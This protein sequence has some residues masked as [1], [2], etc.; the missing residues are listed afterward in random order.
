MNIVPMYCCISRIGVEIYPMMCVTLRVA[1][2]NR[3]IFLFSIGPE[4][5]FFL[6][7]RRGPPDLSFLLGRGVLIRGSAW[8][9]R[10]DPRRDQ[11]CSLIRFDHICWRPCHSFWLK[12]LTTIS[13]SPHERRPKGE[14][15]LN[16][17]EDRR[18]AGPCSTAATMPPDLLFTRGGASPVLRP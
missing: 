4:K 18:A 15:L 3:Q 9:R 10:I 14:Y 11:G 12:P 17:P 7:I 16:R 13:F 1:S 2:N 5:N 6:S 8:L